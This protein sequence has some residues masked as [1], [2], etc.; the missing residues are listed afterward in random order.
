MG[1]VYRATDTNLKRSVA[2]KVLPSSVAADAERLARFQREAEVLAALN[3]PHIAQI[4][5]LEKSDGTIALVMELVEGPTLADRIAQGA[6]PIDETLSIANQIAEALEAAHEQGIIHR[7]LKPA[8]IK[9]RADGTVKVL[10]FG[11]AKAMEPAGPV[12]GDPATMISPAM[13]EAGV[14]LGTAAYMAPEQARG[15]AVDRRADIWAFGAV[16][17]EMLSGRQLFKG[18]TVSDMVAAVL[19]DEIDWTAVPA[20]TPEPVR[21]LIER[22]LDRDAKRRLQA[23]GEARVTLE[24]A[25][26]RATAESVARRPAAARPPI[27]AR[28]RWLAA[29]VV[30]FAFAGALVLWQRGRTSPGA[31]ETTSKDGRSIAVLPFVN[32]G[33]SADDEYFADGMTDE[34]IASL[35]KVPNLHVAARS[36]AFSFKGQ[37]TEVRNVAKRLGVD[38][39]LEG[40]VR[41]SGRRVRVTASLV[42]A[43]DGL[44]IWSSTFEN[45]GGDPFAVQD[46][47]TRGV[48]S[49]LSL[50]LA[51][52]ALQASQAGRTKDPEAH[53]L[54]LRGL[55]SANASSE[56]DLRRALEFYQQAIARDPA[57]AL[58]YTGVAWVHIFLADAYVPPSEAYPKAKAAAQTALERDSRLADAHALL[59]YSTAG[60]WGDR[61]TVDHDFSRALE[62]DPNGVNVLLLRGVDRCFNGRRDEALVDLGRAAQLDPLSPTAPMMQEL[63]YYVDRRYSDVIDVHRKTQAIDPSFV[64]FQSWAGAAYRELGDYQ[65]ALREYAVSAKALSDAPQYGLALTYLR[66]GRGTDAREIMRSMDERARTQYVPFI[67]RAEVHAALGDL[68][69]SVALL[70]QALDR[71]ESFMFVLREL[72]EM[73]PLL[74]DSRAR[75]IVE[76]A[77]AMRT[78][79]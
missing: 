15:K 29:A 70:Q 48:V 64:Y 38:S 14:I 39:I 54:Y 6:I 73:T 16:V 7:D 49:G 69:T 71:R 40:T 5:R 41:R 2:I 44:Q 18:E 63:C 61:A 23:I 17:Y 60:E 62:L 58:A 78:G 20:A 13:T 37:K 47:V 65:A 75:R 56:A 3:H 74:K 51:G 1:E 72:P 35:G 11:L 52:T 55:A 43:A 25:T 33:G 68:D 57:F 50:Q 46:Q 30:V 66:M 12:S 8:N 4:H 76:R 67:T 27:M 9:V 26:A 31:S 24:E 59:A 77:D 42:S 36:S 22:C 28:G 19:R 53:D 79:K 34:L 21:R 32:N 45:D 10:D